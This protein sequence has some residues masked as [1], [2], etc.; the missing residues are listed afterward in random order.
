MVGQLGL[1]VNKHKVKLV[2]GR[3]E[4]FSQV[5]GHGKADHEAVPSVLSAPAAAQDGWRQRH[6][7]RGGGPMLIVDVG[8]VIDVTTKARR[9]GSRLDNNNA[10]RPT[11]RV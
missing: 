11:R 8:F 4:G 9:A 7:P 6:V 10:T 1:I 2:A 5:S 3:P